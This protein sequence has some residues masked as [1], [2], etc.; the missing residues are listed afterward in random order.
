MPKFDITVRGKT[1]HVEIPDPG[2]TPLRVLVDGEAFEVGIVGTSTS[3][4]AFKPAEPPPPA[5]VPP[6][7]PPVRP[8]PVPR[9]A[10]S[11]EV[12]GG[13]EVLAPMPGTVLSIPARVGQ[14]VAPGDVLVI[15]EAMKMKNPIRATHPGVVTDVLVQPGQSV[16]HG[17]LLVR[18][19]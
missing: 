17:E 19:G 4:A 14:S 10:A 8:F 2:A 12:A 16:A 13:H 5:S 1:Y 11:A 15:L 9:P 18:L 7:L 3:T 6:P